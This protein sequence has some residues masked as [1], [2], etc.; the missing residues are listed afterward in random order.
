MSQKI[1]SS[2]KKSRQHSR[3]A[4]LVLLLMSGSAMAANVAAEAPSEGLTDCDVVGVNY[5]DNPELTRSEKLKLMEQAFY[6]SLLK[7]EDCNTNLSSSA[8]GGSGADS[9]G[10]GSGASNGATSVSSESL[11]GTEP[12]ETEESPSASSSDAEAFETEP[13][14][15]GPITA[16]SN[17][18]TVPKDIPPAENDDALAAQIRLAAEAE[19]DPETRKKL[20]NEYRKY[21]GMSIEQ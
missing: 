19:T 7:F 1:K 8:G 21:K 15:N 3:A 12:G 13:G 16:T 20:W 14:G 5:Q 9:P 11:Q 6:A 17:N 2:L 18:G 4:C 10:S